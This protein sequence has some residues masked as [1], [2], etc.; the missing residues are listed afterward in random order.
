MELESVVEAKESNTPV[1]REASKDA[2][3]DVVMTADD[4]KSPVLRVQRTPHVEKQKATP[5]SVSARVSTLESARSVSTMAL[6]I[7]A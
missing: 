3:G 7:L 6:H 5:G 1:P 4:S 2:S